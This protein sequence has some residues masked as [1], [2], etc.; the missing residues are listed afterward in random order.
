MFKTEAMLVCEE[1]E[2]RIAALEREKQYKIDADMTLLALRTV[3]K[4]VE[5]IP[6]L[7]RERLIDAFA[8]GDQH[9]YWK[10]ERYN[11]LGRNK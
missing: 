8:K 4:S 7:Q 6:E 2:K 5:G 10:Y 3:I 9:G 1:L 11:Y